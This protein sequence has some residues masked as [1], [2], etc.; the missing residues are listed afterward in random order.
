VGLLTL[1]LSG[2]THRFAAIRPEGL[3]RH[4]ILDYPQLYPGLAELRSRLGAAAAL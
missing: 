4:N 2:N 1:A 3:L